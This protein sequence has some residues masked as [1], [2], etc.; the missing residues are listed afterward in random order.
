[1]FNTDSAGHVL[2][3]IASIAISKVTGQVL[4]ILTVQAL[5]SIAREKLASWMDR[6]RQESGAFTMHVD[7]ELDIRWL[8]HED[9]YF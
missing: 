7:G 4:P 1:M 3:S 6:L 5:S 2:Y 8:Y 9:G